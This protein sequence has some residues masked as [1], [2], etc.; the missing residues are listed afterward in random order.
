MLKLMTSGNLLKAKGSSELNHYPYY[1]MESKAEK[2]AQIK[3]KISSL[4]D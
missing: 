2:L 1:Q 4:L 3:G